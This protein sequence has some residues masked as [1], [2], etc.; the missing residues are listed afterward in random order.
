[1]SIKNFYLDKFL[2]EEY[3]YKCKYVNIKEGGVEEKLRIFK[4][5]GDETR[6]KIVEMLLKGEMCVCEIIPQLRKAQPTVS[7]QLKKLE[8]LGIVE[9][10][11]EGKSVY[12]NLK[13]ERVRKILQLFAD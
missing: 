5:L 8:M 3:I 11:K 9:S 10:R 13:N 12:Y 1:L 6:L 2:R 7:L 4:A